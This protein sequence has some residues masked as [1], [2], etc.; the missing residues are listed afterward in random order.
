[1]NCARILVVED[2]W[3]IA[4]DLRHRLEKEG[5]TVVGVYDR[6][7]DAVEAAR[8]ECP[9]IVLMDIMLAGEMDGI[10][11]AAVIRT[12][13]DVPV[14][15]LTAYADPLIIERAKSTEPAAYL[16]KPFEDRELAS[17]IEIALYKGEMERRL[18]KSERFLR[19]LTGALAEGV[20]VLD[21]EGRVRFLNPEAERLLGWREEELLGEP[22]LARILPD[23]A[24]SSDILSTLADGETRRVEE[25][26]F[27][28]REAGAF[29]VAYA[30]SPLPVEG[31]GVGVAVA[32]QDISERKRARD[33]LHAAK[34]EAEAA[35]RAKSQFL[36][37]VS[38]EIRTPM[39][40]IL[41]MAEL[42]LITD[43]DDTQRGYLEVQKTS[44]RM[45]VGVIDDILDLAQLEAGGG[46][47]E[48]AEFSLVD[49]FESLRG[50]I[51]PAARE[52]G[53]AFSMARE[54]SVPEVLTGD[55]R[56][57]RQILFNLLSNAVKFTE[58]GAVSLA[59]A[60]EEWAELHFRVSDSGI[61]IADEEQVHIFEPF[62]QVDS[63]I[64]RRYGGSG[65]GLAIAS[66]LA[67]RMG[68]RL[69]VESRPG[70]GSVFHLCLSLGLHN[71]GRGVPEVTDAPSDD[72]PLMVEGCAPAPPG[73]S[74]LLAEDSPD[75]A[76]LVDA[77]LR[78]TAH[79]LE[80]VENGA[81]ALER[82]REA[83]FDLMLMDIQ[84][85][86]MDGYE[87]T[88]RIREWE[89]EQGWARTPI[90]A[91]TAHALKEDEAKSLAAGCD[92]HITKP[93]RKAALLELIE[94]QAV[95]AFGAGVSG[96]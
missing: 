95:G 88:R 8:R 58:H 74:I 81:L 42:L 26:L 25:D 9:E 1:M 24:G 23:P 2:E 10:E 21:A 20:V 19:G 55:G 67:E 11:A 29:P 35:S 33:E 79:R 22:L 36:A 57:L 78:H 73:L 70:E 7:E 80:V 76:L 49:L 51:E 69:W 96:V 34:E 41:G 83:R 75:N 92:A 18:R 13:C 61:G 94:R 3:V 56:R 15:Y 71:E 45:L 53:L 5:H 90:F 27:L 87:A 77:Y 31:D 59:V 6:G 86:V 16:I 40:A 91:F 65:I 32:F 82:F 37:M 14:V 30:V 48:A 93:V 28:H 47:L 43:V 64:T 46:T 4:D 38:H 62:S 72:G 50:V 52:K 54:P 84:M 17:T 39:N 63:T 66:R 89:R 12:C 85:P 68:G 60:A 44:G